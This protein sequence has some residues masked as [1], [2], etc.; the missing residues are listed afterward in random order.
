MTCPVWTPYAFEVLSSYGEL[1]IRAAQ[2]IQSHQT[3]NTALR[4]KLE[5][6]TNELELAERKV[7]DQARTIE[8]LKKEK[9]A[10][11]YAAAVMTV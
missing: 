8:K 2:S 11:A 10:L 3:A 6:T 4:R 5:A 1:G 7:R 9:D